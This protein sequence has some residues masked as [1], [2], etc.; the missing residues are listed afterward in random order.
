M[1]AVQK[2]RD[3]GGVHVLTDEIAD[4]AA[5]HHDWD[6]CLLVPAQ[7]RFFGHGEAGA[8]AGA[9]ALTFGENKPV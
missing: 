7:P 6:Q 8:L 5:A 4:E 9:V 1:D 3:N 2:G